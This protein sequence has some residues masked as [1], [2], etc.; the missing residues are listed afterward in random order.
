MSEDQ[1]QDEPVSE[2]HEP[3]RRR[4]TAE[5]MAESVQEPVIVNRGTASQE[6]V[7]DSARSD[8]ATSAGTPTV[9]HAPTAAATAAPTRRPAG[10]RRIKM[11]VSHIDPMSAL[12]LGFLVSVVIGVMIVLA[13][14]LI[15]FILDGMYV[16]SQLNELLVTLN[17]EALLKLAQYLEFGRWMSFAVII[18]IVDIVLF[19]LLSL[20]GALIYNLISALVGGVKV[21]LSDE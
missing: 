2:Q 16:F 12:K 19:T 3:P 9:A 1:N 17:S 7:P 4:S 14:A 15:W 21:T 8:T 5:R 11:T 10:I 6:H 13:M 20:V 18:S